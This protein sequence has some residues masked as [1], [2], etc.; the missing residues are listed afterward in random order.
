MVRFRPGVAGGIRQLHELIGE[1]STAI[2]ADLIRLGLRLRWVGDGTGRLTVRDL[3]ALVSTLAGDETSA[4]FRSRHRDAV[5]VA[6]KVRIDTLNALMLLDH[7]LRQIGGDKSAKKFT[8]LRGYPGSPF[9]PER[10]SE[11]FS[12]SAA[13]GKYRRMTRAETVAWLKSRGLPTPKRV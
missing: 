12:P 11:L 3:W 13:L 10:P 8:P 6:D 7:H 2:E 5:P 4:L 1:H 9:E